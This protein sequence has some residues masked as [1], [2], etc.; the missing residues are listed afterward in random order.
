MATIVSSNKAKR[1]G[2]A[3]HRQVRLAVEGAMTIYQA[4]EDKQALLAALERAD[5]LEIDLSRVSEMDTAGMQLLALLKR[6][7]AR[8]GQSV[9]HTAHSAASLEVLDRYNLGGYFGDP[10]LISFKAG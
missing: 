2:G 7:A 3:R 8:R 6:E 1:R 4:R 10:V 9:R 5:E